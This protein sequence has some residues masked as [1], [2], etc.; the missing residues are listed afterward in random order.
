MR[1]SEYYSTLQDA[2]D[3]ALDGDTIQSRIAVFNNDVNA[4]QDISMVFDG[5]YNCNYSDITGTTAFNG[6]M[7]ISSG[8]VTI[9]N[10]VFGN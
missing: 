10:Y 2:Y 9:G 1:A 6:N 3:A 8:T 5:G 4:D 7:T